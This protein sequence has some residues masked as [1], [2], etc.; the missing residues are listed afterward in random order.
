MDLLII[1]QPR[2][3]R[4]LNHLAEHG[5]ASYL[6]LEYRLGILGMHL[7]VAYLQR[8]KLITGMPKE[9]RGIPRKYEITPLGRCAIAGAVFQGEQHKRISVKDREVWIPRPAEPS[10]AGAMRAYS[11]PSLAGQVPAHI[12]GKQTGVAA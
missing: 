6:D 4:A 10:R 5:P 9:A 8:K 3:Q 11:I 2:Y 12:A 1:K 7:V